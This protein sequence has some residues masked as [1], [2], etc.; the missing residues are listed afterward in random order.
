MSIVSFRF[1]L[2][3]T[4][5]NNQINAKKKTHITINL[6]NIA[7]LIRTICRK[8]EQIKKKPKKLITRPRKIIP[9][10]CQV[11]R[12]R[13]VFTIITQHNCSQI[14]VFVFTIICFFITIIIFFFTII[15]LFF[16]IIFF[17]SQLSVLFFSQKCTGVGK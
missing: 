10:S 16:T 5:S 12:D 8:F 17:S 11:E 15:C 6:K 3:H 7:T 1:G 9:V 14:S 4:T 13:I 2:R